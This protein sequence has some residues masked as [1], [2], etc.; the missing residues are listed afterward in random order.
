MQASKQPRIEKI[1]VTGPFRLTVQWQN[2]AENTINM[3]G[4]VY[5]FAPFAPLRDP[6]SFANLEIMGWGDGI[7]WP[8]HGLDYSADSLHFLTQEQQPLLPRHLKLWQQRM[9][10]SNN[11]AADWLGVSLSTWKTYIRDG[12]NI[13][14]VVQIA[15]RAAEQQPGIFQAQYKPRHTG[16]PARQLEM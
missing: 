6:V 14:Q 13:P 15:I 2:G 3:E 9:K 16:R 11:E 12:S 10:L 5:G 1:D 7:E 8:E 4:V